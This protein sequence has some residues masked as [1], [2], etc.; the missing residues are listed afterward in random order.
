[1]RQ[2]FIKDLLVA[3][4][5]TAVGL[6]AAIFAANPK[7]G[8]DQLELTF[9][10][11]LLYLVGCSMVGGGIMYPLKKSGMGATLGAIG[12]AILSAFWS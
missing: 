2:F 7:L 5:I 9:G 12:G 8:P 10:L 1:V 11:F 3:T 6:A 4:A